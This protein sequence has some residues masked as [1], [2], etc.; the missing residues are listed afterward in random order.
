MLAAPSPSTTQTPQLPPSATAKRP[1]RG[2][3]RNQRSG[4]TGN[5]RTGAERDTTGQRAS[6]GPCL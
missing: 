2:W 5:V 6:H 3:K 4:G 1:S